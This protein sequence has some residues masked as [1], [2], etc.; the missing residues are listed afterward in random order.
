MDE[1]NS[2][3]AD[4]RPM[5]CQVCGRFAELEWHCISRDEDDAAQ[6]EAAKT[7]EDVGYWLCADVCHATV[8]ELMRQDTDQGRSYRAFGSMIERLASVVTAGQRSYRRQAFG[9]K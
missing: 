7:A 4:Q 5:L 3:T 2:N 8:H 9:E 1:S 6:C